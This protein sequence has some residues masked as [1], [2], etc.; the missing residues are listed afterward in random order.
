M[1]VIRNIN[2]SIFFFC[3]LKNGFRKVSCQVLKI[4][5]FI[6]FVSIITSCGKGQTVDK[7]KT[8]SFFS[9][10]SIKDILGFQEDSLAVPEYINW[11]KEQRGVAYDQGENDKFNLSIL[12]KPLPLEAA[13]SVPRNELSYNKI[14]EYEQIKE[15]FHYIKIELAQKSQSVKELNASTPSVLSS[16]EKSLYIIANDSDTIINYITEFFPGQL[17]NQPHQMLVI[18]PNDKTFTKLRTVIEGEAFGLKN[19]DIAISDK[20]IKSFPYIKL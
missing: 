19:L 12:Y 6:S 10:S 14:K 13:L 9:L 15:G 4:G 1:I 16:I 17:L 2:N 8:N 18:V 20:Q 5:I 3:H 7:I 11:L